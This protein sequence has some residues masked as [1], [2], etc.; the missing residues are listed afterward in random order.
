MISIQTFR[1]RQAAA[2]ILVNARMMQALR[3]QAGQSVLDRHEMN[4]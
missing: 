2:S 4:A 3:R 1:D